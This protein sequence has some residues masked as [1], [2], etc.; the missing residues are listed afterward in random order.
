MWLIWLV[1]SAVLV[2]AL[3]RGGWSVTLVFLALGLLF[4]AFWLSPW[5]GGSS[6]RHRDVMALPEE[7]RQRVV[8]WRPGDVFCTRFRGGLGRHAKALLWV[9]VAQDR[10]AEAFADERGEGASPVVLVDGETLVNPDPR[11]VLELL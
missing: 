5:Y 4:V 9:N 7:E 3:S 2:W 11:R 1:A 6:L 8:Y 10:E